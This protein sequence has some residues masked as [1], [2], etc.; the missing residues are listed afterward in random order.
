VSAK[1]S[2]YAGREEWPQPAPPGCGL[3]HFI[4]HFIAATVTN[5]SPNLL[6]GIC[7]YYRFVMFGKSKVFAGKITFVFSRFEIVA[8]RRLSSFNYDNVMLNLWTVL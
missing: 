7:D 4:I 8:T 2:V 6:G 5:R 1:H 3:I